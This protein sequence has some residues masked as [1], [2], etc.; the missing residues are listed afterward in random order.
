MYGPYLDARQP[1]DEYL[2]YVRLFHQAP[3][4]ARF[5]P[6]SRHPGPEVRILEVQP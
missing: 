1:Q 5:T 6:S 4:V 3:E 2:D